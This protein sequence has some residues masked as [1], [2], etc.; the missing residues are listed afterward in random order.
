MNPMGI[1]GPGWTP[2]SIQPNTG[3]PAVNANVA[4]YAVGADPMNLTWPIPTY[5]QPNYSSA[6]VQT[7]GTLL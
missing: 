1:A 5:T 6:A 4:S 3:N 2:N 7:G